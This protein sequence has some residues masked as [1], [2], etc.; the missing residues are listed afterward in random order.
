MIEIIKET[1]EEEMKHAIESLKG[2]LQKIRT[3][4]AHASMLDSVKVNYYGSLSPLNQVAS[5]STPDARSFMLAPWEASVLK[6]IE[7]AIVK[8]DLGLAPINDGKVIRLKLPEVTEERRKDLVKQAKKT[9][10]DS[11]ISIR[12][13]RKD[14]NDEIKELLKNKEISEDD[15]K[16]FTEEIQKLTDDYIKKVDDIGTAKEK[17]IMTV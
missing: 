11:R 8:S 17:D 13:K 1:A 7:A 16:R 9:V 3:G 6:D 15:S 2:E 10:E 4:K 5:I 14:A 12:M